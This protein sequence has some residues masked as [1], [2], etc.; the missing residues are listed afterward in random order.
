MA[1][2]DKN[3]DELQELTQ[4]V[5]IPQRLEAAYNRRI[6]TLGKSLWQ[7]TLKVAASGFG[8][9]VL[10]AAGI[11]L[12]GGA[13]VFGFS[14]ATG[15]ITV[16]SALLGATQATAVE[17]IAIGIPEGIAMGLSQAGNLIFSAGGLGLLGF[18]GMIGAVSDVRKHQHK[19]TAEMARA[20]SEA[21]AMEREQGL[22]REVRRIKENSGELFERE[23]PEQQESMFS[24]REAAR[25]EAQV[26]NP[27]R[28]L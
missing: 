21:Y 4:D 25:R 19:L 17:A 14:A 15:A 5:D 12:L 1:I 22:V 11:I 13:L 2:D 20:E 27:Y 26:N 16:G 3:L 10:I 28:Q 23:Q 7:G 9:G 6:K 24:A 18:G 8:K